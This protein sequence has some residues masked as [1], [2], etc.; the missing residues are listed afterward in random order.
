VILLHEPLGT[1]TILGF[2]LMFAGML[3]SQWEI[4]FKREGT[5][6]KRFTQR[7]RGAEEE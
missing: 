6:G 7:R 3:T 2:A 1:W 4:I 5:G